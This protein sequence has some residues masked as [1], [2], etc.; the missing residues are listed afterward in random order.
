[1]HKRSHPGS[2]QKPHGL[3]PP[4]PR[5]PPL[6][7]KLLVP[8]VKYQ[9]HKAHVVPCSPLH[10]SFFGEVLAAPDSNESAPGKFRDKQT[11]K[12]NQE[13]RTAVVSRGFTSGRDEGSTGCVSNATS[14]AQGPLGDD[15][16]LPSFPT[17]PLRRRGTTRDHFSSTKSPTLGCGRS[18]VHWFKQKKLM[19]HW[20]R[21][22]FKKIFK[23]IHFDIA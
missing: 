6:S 21:T 16:Q 9:E 22:K 20:I 10:D 2:P 13:A 11:N 14:S 8:L 18:Q 15:L 23:K 4:V 17:Y 7:S 19:V 12:Q 3:R 1:M 5:P